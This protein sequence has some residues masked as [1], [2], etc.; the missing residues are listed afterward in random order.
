[1]EESLF[2]KVEAQ[3]LP[4]A[5]PELVRRPVMHRASLLMACHCTG[6]DGQVLHITSRNGPS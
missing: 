3:V 5:T 1:M 6:I 2:Y 4:I